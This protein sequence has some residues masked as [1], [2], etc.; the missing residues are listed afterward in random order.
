MDHPGMNPTTEPAAVEPPSRSIEALPRP[1]W[2]LLL[3]LALP[4]LAQ[5]ALTLTVNLSDR[6]LAGHLEVLTPEEQLQATG[7]RLLAQVQA[8]SGNPWASLGSLQAAAQIEARQVAFLAAQTTAHYLA[9]FI[10]SYSILVSVGSTALVARFIGAGQHAQAVSVTHQSL[11]LA[12]VLGLTATA[13]TFLGGLALIVDLLQLRGDAAQFAVAYLQPLFALMVFQIIET[14]GIAC[15]VGAGDTRP[16]LWVTLAVAALNLPLAWGFCLGLGPLPQLGFVGIAVGTAVSHTLGG[17]AIL[18]LLARGRSGLKLSL[19]LFRPHPQ[20][21]YRLL[22][23]SLPAG[24]DSLSIVAGQFWFLS[25][26]NTLGEVASSAHGIALLWEAL[27]YLSGAAFGVAAMSVVGQN[28][29]AGRPD[30]ATRGGWMAC[31]LACAVMSSMGLLFFI[32]APAMFRVFCPLPEQRPI[33]DAG[34]DVLRLIAFAMPF[35][36]PT[37]VFLSC[38]RSA[39]DTRVPVLFTWIGFFVVRIP[40]AYVL[41]FPEI[42]LGP[43]GSWPGLNLG[44]YGAWLAMFADIVVRGIFFLV[45]FARGAWQHQ[46][47]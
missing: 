33:I 8:G 17:L 41:M 46:Q 37:I 44:L 47:V 7:L 26:V 31:G 6:F 27:G 32:L 30:E 23:V 24:L 29:G 40:L 14:A 10:M 18:T 34:V 20:L 45:R 36:A 11:L 15:L 3:A 25:I 19:P 42:H 28:L 21:I 12:L 22:R 35:L 4:V 39:G 5:Q 38:L 16:G 9:W 1:T 43:L 2:G 13:F